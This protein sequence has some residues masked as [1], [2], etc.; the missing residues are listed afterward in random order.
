MKRSIYAI[1][2]LSCFF[3]LGLSHAATDNQEQTNLEQASYLHQWGYSDL[4]PW[5]FM[6]YVG[7]SAKEP[8]GRILKGKF[9]SVNETLYTGELAYTLSR[10]NP[11]RR[12]FSY[13]V[14]EVQ[15]AGNVTTRDGMYNNGLIYEFDPYIIFRWTQ[16]PWNQ[17]LVTTLAAA[18]GVSYVT[19]VPWTEKRY[20]SDCARLLNY[21]MFEVT[22]ALPSNPRLQL[23]ARIHHRSG[24]YGL[25]GAGNTGSN[26]V[27]VGVR[28]Y[29]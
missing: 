2:F 26:A 3:A 24:G 16:F 17:Y 21:L 18:E 5:S 19:K 4:H 14:S 23:V 25:Y 27:G 11:I 7:R 9:T 22:F 1:I 20:N 29:F 15:L 13:V 8:I 28:Y 12:F 6:F 10:S